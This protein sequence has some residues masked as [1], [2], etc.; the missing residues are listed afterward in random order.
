MVLNQLDSRNALSRSMNEALAE[1][2]VPALVSGLSRR[3]A[4]RSAALEGASVYG[5]GHRGAVAAREVEAL[6]EEV[7]K[8]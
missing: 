7:L 4:F 3:A 6:I 8:A 2:E 5:L 1:F